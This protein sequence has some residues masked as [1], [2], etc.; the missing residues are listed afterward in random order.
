MLP[1][2]PKE[3]PTEADA[4]PWLSSF[5]SLAKLLAIRLASS[6]VSTPAVFASVI[7]EGIEIGERLAVSVD[8]FE[9]AR[10]A[11]HGSGRREAAVGHCAR[12]QQVDAGRSLRPPIGHAGQCPRPPRLRTDSPS[13]SKQ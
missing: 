10:Q 11:L 4:Y 5:G 9:A 2:S 8:D 7:V 13:G 3:A 1:A 12:L 6:M